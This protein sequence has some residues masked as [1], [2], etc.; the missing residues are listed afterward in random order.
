VTRILILG[1]N[2]QVARHT[3][4]ML[5]RDTDTKLSASRTDRAR[6]SAMESEHSDAFCKLE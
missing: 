3:T 4:R 5:L 2:G 1:A 6:T